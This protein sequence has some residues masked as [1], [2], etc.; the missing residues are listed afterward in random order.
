MSFKE[1][2][3]GLRFDQTKPQSFWKHP[4][5]LPYVKLP[6]TDD[7]LEAFEQEIGYQLTEAMVDL[8]C[9]QN[10]GYSRYGFD[11]L[12]FDMV[13][14]IGENFPTLRLLSREFEEYEPKELGIRFSLDGL[15]AFDGDGH[16]Y[17]CLDYRE[18]PERPQVTFVDL[19]NDD[20]Q[21]IA[22][23]FEAFLQQLVLKTQETWVICSDK[24]LS[25]LA[26]VFQSHI[27]MEIEVSDK[28]ADGYDSYRF[29][30]KHDDIFLEPNRV[31]Y[32]F[33]RQN[34][35]GYA[36]LALYDGKMAQRYPELPAEYSLLMIDNPDLA[37]R[38]ID[39]LKGVLDIVPLESLIE[40]DDGCRNKDE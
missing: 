2:N 11:G 19:E 3:K 1:E 15:L 33:A 31:P 34:E 16:Y 30:L 37:D 14:G 20:V 27:S 10:D 23:S 12:P 22:E 21:I 29:M 32:V 36:D 6:L 4:L 5:Y 8:F 28:E 38:L 26:L 40:K 17:W 39:T 25:E 18:T 7:R 13:W 9:V 24:P 35:G